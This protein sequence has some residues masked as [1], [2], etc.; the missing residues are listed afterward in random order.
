M[1]VLDSLQLPRAVV[2]SHSFG[3]S[4]ANF[5]AAYHPDRVAG[6]IYLDSAF[7][8]ASLYTN[9]TWMGSNAPFPPI[10]P[11]DSGDVA[12]VTLYLA[13]ITGPGYPTAEVLEL[14]K[15]PRVESEIKM[16]S[17]DVLV[18]RGAGQAEFT[19][20]HAPVLAIYRVPS[21]SEEKYPFF[22]SLDSLGRQKAVHR[23]LDE[24]S[25]M[26]AQR[27]KFRMALPKAKVLEIIGGR[28]YVFLTHASE[29]T[30]EMRLFLSSLMLESRAQ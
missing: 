30:H 12:S 2:V 10:P 4:E 27:A 5:L 21:S 1:A 8:F 20:I 6:L 19:K 9:A 26:N 23:F 3:G 28:H 24:R 14:M 17:I 11:C 22:L 16:D 15:R 25:V 18:Q 13:R 7:D 29:V